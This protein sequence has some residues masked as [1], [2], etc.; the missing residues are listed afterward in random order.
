MTKRNR[1]G[2]NC[3]GAMW[4]SRIAG[5]A[6]GAALAIASSTA[7]ASVAY[8]EGVSGDLSNSGTA[9]TALSVGVGHN[10]VS[11]MTGRDQAGVVDR[12]YFTFTVA[13]DQFLTAITLLSATSLPGRDVENPLSFIG[14]QSG[15]EVTVDPAATT[16]AGLLGW[17]H[18]GPGDA[19]SDILDNIGAG[20][21]ATGFTGPLGP[22]SYAF[23]VQDTGSGM[24]AYSFDFII[25]AVPE[26]SSWAMMLTGFGL[27]GLALRRRRTGQIFKG[28]SSARSLAM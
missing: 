1:P 15:N 18:Y 21:G 27:L 7:S 24:A 28:P 20:F 14:V 22:G 11:G 4:M 9:P 8:D 12:D 25:A 2:R 13:P 5:I 17:T 23:W 19:S 3:K 16:A 26:P 6:A 10:E